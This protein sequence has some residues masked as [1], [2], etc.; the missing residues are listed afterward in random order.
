MNDIGQGR[1]DG[2]P[3]ANECQALSKPCEAVEYLR[4][5]V[6][7]WSVRFI[8]VELESEVISC[9]D[10]NA[11]LREREQGEKSSEILRSEPQQEG[12]SKRVR[13]GTQVTFSLACPSEPLARN[14]Q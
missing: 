9:F 13:H 2:N 7:F 1:R 4:V 8:K 3:A 6:G 12:Q 11:T 10:A 5:E 14:V